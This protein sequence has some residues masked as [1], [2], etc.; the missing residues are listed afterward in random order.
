MRPIVSVIGD[1]VARVRAKYDPT[2]AEKPFYMHGHP[3][4]I[5]RILSEM[6]ANGQ[7]KFKK[8]PAICL[9]Q[10]FDEDDNGEGI[11]ADL[12]ILIIEETKPS[13]EA[14]ERYQNSFTPVLYPLF[15]LFLSEYKKMPGIQLS[16]ANISYTKTDRLYWGRTGLYGN[17]GNIANDF[18][19]AIEINNLS[20][21]MSRACQ[22]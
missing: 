12:N 7:L 11:E 6:T 1:V 16:P 4:E 21:R 17:S 3:L 10:D 9:F 5:V 19:D 15:D 13:F 20:F 18:I 14:S 22:Y 2:G 8:F